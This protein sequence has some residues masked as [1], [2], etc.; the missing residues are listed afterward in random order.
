MFALLIGLIM[1][2]CRD[3]EFG[4][5]KKVLTA[6]G[7][8]LV[9]FDVMMITSFLQNADEPALQTPLP[10]IVIWLTL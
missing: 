7:I 1:F 2:S 5:A 3:L 10:A 8:G 9:L 6:T 4:S